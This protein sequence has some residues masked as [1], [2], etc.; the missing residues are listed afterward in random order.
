MFPD[1]EREG[2]YHTADATL[3]FFHAVDRYV[4]ATDDRDTLRILLPTLHDII[5]HHLRGTRFGIGV[6]PGDGLLRQGAGRLSTH[7]DGRQGGRLGGDAAARQG[8]GDQRALLQ[9]APAARGV[10]R[11]PED[12]ERGRATVRSA[13]RPRARV[14]QP[15]LLVRTGGYLYDV[16]DGES[17]DDAAC[18]PNQIFAISLTASRSRPRTAGS[19]VVDT[20]AT[21]PVDAVWAAVAR[22]RPS[23]LSRPVLR[24]SEIARRGLSPGH[25]L[26]VADRSV[27]RRVAS[28]VSRRT[29][30]R[31]ARCSPA[32]ARISSEAGVGSI[33]EI[34]DAELPYTPRGCIAQAWSVAEVLRALNRLNELV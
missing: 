33:S 14:V 13:C 4:T 12:G 26:G 9:R 7:L 27:H 29:R 6:D 18:R 32:S 3:W 28:R 11:E 19:A 5:E 20:V 25:G 24:R 8:R 17:G 34:F 1:G 2:L 30:Q 16:V 22:A 15:P 23:G 21:T 31:P 10:G